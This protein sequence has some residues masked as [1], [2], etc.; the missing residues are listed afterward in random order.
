M[1][2]KKFIFS[3]EVKRILHDKEVKYQEKEYFG[4]ETSKRIFEIYNALGPEVGCHFVDPNVV[5]AIAGLKGL[6]DAHWVMLNKERSERIKKLND[7]MS[8]HGLKI[9]YRKNLG[10]G[11]TLES[12]SIYSLKGLERKTNTTKIPGVIP[13]DSRSGWEGFNKWDSEISKSLELAQKREEIPAE[14]RVGVLESIILGYP[15]QAIWDFEECLRTRR[16]EDMETG[17]AQADILSVS[18]YAQKY[19]G[20]IPEFLFYPEHA[21]DPEIISYIKEAREVLKE[22]YD[23]PWHQELA[24]DPV[25]LKAREETDNSAKEA[26]R[27]RREKR[28]LERKEN[29]EFT[30]KWYDN[31]IKISSI[32]DPKERYERL[33]VLHKETLH[34]YI[35][36]LQSITIEKARQKISDG[37]TIAEVVAHIVAWEEWQIQVFNDPN[38][39]GRLKEQINLCGYFDAENNK[40]VDFKN[41]D[42][43]NAY[44]TEKYSKWKWKN[45][46]Q[47]ATST[48]TKLREIFPDIPSD[49]WINFLESTPSHQWKILPNKTITVPAGWYLW[50]VSLEHEAV[51]LR[52]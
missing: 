38:R 46:Q 9:S 47:K 31:L 39:Q 6:A 33:V 42:D 8:L 1:E 36:T 51:K 17:L 7:Q 24:R 43:F 19:Q 40:V 5:L 14:V 35:S 3:R 41:V 22:F 4:S 11:F 45:I 52:K 12:M 29:I 15:D 16:K 27:Q 32:P 13:F 21:N 26:I 18:S 23:S 34:F 44:Q 49:G 20:A 2:S 30:K 25:F 28:N 48:A 10:D 50:M 37:R